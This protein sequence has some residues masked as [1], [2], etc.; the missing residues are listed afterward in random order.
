MFMNVEQVFNLKE[1]FNG[2]LENS[3]VK[4]PTSHS[5]SMTE[6]ANFESSH[7]T[8]KEND[9]YGSQDMTLKINEFFSDGT[10]SLLEAND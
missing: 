7:N 3:S 5:G 1:L 2:I 4:S 8:W 10:Q 9:L 6:M